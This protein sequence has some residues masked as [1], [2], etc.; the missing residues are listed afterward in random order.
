M[1]SQSSTAKLPVRPRLTLCHDALSSVAEVVFCEARLRSVP[2]SCCEACGFARSV[3]RDADGRATA[4]E[5]GRAALPSGAGDEEPLP[6]QRLA[7]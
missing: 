7:Y 1:P 2:P 6:A 4:V 5:C 3:E